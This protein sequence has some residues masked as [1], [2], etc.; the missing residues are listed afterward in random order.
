MTHIVSSLRIE[1]FK[2]CKNTEEVRLAPFVPLVGYNNAGKSN[3]LSA[4]EWLFKDRLLSESEYTDPTKP[5]V[6][7]GQIEGITEEVINRLDPDHRGPIREYILEGKIKIRRTQPAGAT[8]KSD[9]TLHVLHPESGDYRPN[10]R[11][12][13]NA[14]KALFPE[15][16]RVGAMENAADDASKAKTTTTIGK[17]LLELCGSIEERH[18]TI[19]QR[20]LTAI[21]RRMSAEG[22]RRLPELDQIDGAINEKIE[23][24]FPGISLKLHFEVPSFQDIFRAGTVKVLEDAGAMRDFAAY[25]H[26]TQ[27]AIQMALIR[28]LADVRQSI[29]SPTTTL[30]LIDEPELYMHPF[31]IEQV[32]EALHSLSKH[33]YQVVFSTHSAQM[34]TVDRAQTAVLVRKSPSRGTFV[35]KRL[36][37]ALNVVVPDARAQA[38]HLFSLS[39]ST[40]VLFANQVVVTEGKTELRLLPSIYSSITGS[41]LGQH[42][43]ALVEAGS[44]DSIS[45]TLKILA[46]MDIPTRAIVDL[47][48]AF[49]GAVRAGMISNADTNLTALKAILQ[50][51]E[52]EGKC[53]LNPED[54]LPTSKNSPTTAAEAFEL[55][56]EQPEA[57]VHI[58]RLHNQLLSQNVWLW[59][60]GAVEAH[61]GLP[62]KNEAAW[63]AFKTKLETEG[64]D[65]SCTDSLSVRSL[66]DWIR[67][68]AEQDLDA[69]GIYAWE[70]IESEFVA[71]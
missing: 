30:L 24:L 29:D 54:G 21:Y 47:D 4:L 7:E 44:V 67:L 25:G 38:E 61:L 35:R 3:I 51:L 32:R 65:R 15:P 1:N 50:R 28:H 23:D 10:P 20:H 68:V 62:A 5:I 63:A 46:E 42:Q 11:G 37:D 57:R 6:I 26:G 53:K 56:A 40:S 41:T 2:S 9:L 8:K 12:I 52:D 13:W 33:G 48:Y 39:Q 60:R 17:L 43:T 69:L 14:I 70:E 49:R 59:T 45:K 36:R 22:S 31:A 27:R 66:V 34:I 18:A 16:I 64:V 55:L 19:V 71:P 58:E